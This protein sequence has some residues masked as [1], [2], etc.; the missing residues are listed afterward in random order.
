MGE[1]VVPERAPP[2]IVGIRTLDDQPR[3]PASNGEPAGTRTPDREIE[4]LFLSP[5]QCCLR[6]LRTT[7]NLSIYRYLCRSN[8]TGGYADVRGKSV[9]RS[10]ECVRSRGHWAVYTETR[11]DPIRRGRRHPSRRASPRDQPRSGFEFLPRWRRWPMR[12]TLRECAPFPR[13]RDHWQRARTPQRVDGT[14]WSVGC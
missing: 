7:Q 3:L 10:S 11:E 9:P 12:R 6:V 1:E 8:R 14:R 5:V 2:N 13:V 4:I